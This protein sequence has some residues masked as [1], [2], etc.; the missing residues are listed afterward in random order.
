MSSG[1]A[2]ALASCALAL[3]VAEN[4]KSALPAT[5]IYSDSQRLGAVS[6]T[7]QD[8][9]LPHPQSDAV[10]ALIGQ[11]TNQRMAEDVSDDV[12]ANKG[13]DAGPLLISVTGC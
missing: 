5:V 8:A 13:W 2:L 11:Q 3:P 7:D 1:I 6:E 4:E 10:L 12:D 9:N